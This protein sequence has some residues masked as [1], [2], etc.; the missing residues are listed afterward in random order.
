MGDSSSSH[1]RRPPR[2]KIK[3]PPKPPTET[4][5][6]RR[7]QSQSSRGRS[8]TTPAATSNLT[9]MD[10]TCGGKRKFA[11]VAT[12]DVLAGP[13]TKKP[14]APVTTCPA[15]GDSCDSLAS[16]NS[17]CSGVLSDSCLPSAQ[18]LT[19][20]A[21][22]TISTTPTNSNASTTPPTT[23]G[24]GNATSTHN[25]PDDSA[26]ACAPQ[27]Q[28][29]RQPSAPLRSAR[30]DLN[31]P[32]HTTNLPPNTRQVFLTSTNPSYNL[33]KINPIKLAHDIDA[34][35]GA[36][37]SVS[38]KT[39]GSL[40]ITT[41]TLEQVHTLLRL[42]SFSS[43]DIPV[44][45]TVAWESQLSQGK[46]Y[47]PELQDETVDSLLTLLQPKGVVAIR[48]LFSDP[49]RSTV[50][51]YVVTFLG[52]ECPARLTVGYTNYQID[53]Y[54]PSPMRCGKCCRYGHASSAC[55]SKPVCSACGIQGHSR[56][57]CSSPPFCVNCRGP[58]ASYS[59]LCPSFLQ[60]QEACRMT[61]DLG[62]TF[63]EARSRVRTCA[64]AASS[65]HHRPQPTNPPLT[66]TPPPPLLTSHYDFPTI[67]QLMQTQAD[68]QSVSPSPS[69]CL[70]PHSLSHPSSL[71]LSGPLSLQ[72]SPR[73]P[74]SSY[75]PPSHPTSGHST[76]SPPSPWIPAGQQHRH[77]PPPKNSHSGTSPTPLSLDLPP[78][79]P[80]TSLH[81]NSQSSPVS[82][83]QSSQ[84]S[85]FPSPLR[86][87]IL[88]LLPLLLRLF[89]ANHITDKLECFHELGR[90]LQADSLVSD[91]IHTLGLSSATLSQ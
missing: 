86:D 39:S 54:Y 9:P 18:P 19:S 63:S 3:P 91:L 48:K 83:A 52:R 34:C 1:D 85:A 32:S 10:T 45:S 65:S 42:T 62:M 69:S 66:V 47:A 30:L 73:P 33:A 38:H 81:V 49:L 58:H 46:L 43:S 22:R 87:I 51:L 41:N 21:G 12:P 7:S 4:T 61:V 35:C 5:T 14:T 23:Q 6:A 11:P 72:S 64:T 40:L 8:T 68:P 80:Q 16:V 13:L 90:L 24:T 20:P 31:T 26:R 59:K 76:T 57:D 84:S 71:T 89:L 70:S 37:A 27:S 82:P 17:A 15:L 44:R 75:R 79:P 36:V 56:S 55:R 88:A 53:K 67:S 2:G 77:S 50:P 28:S 74:Q 60:E 29:S 25:S 78:A